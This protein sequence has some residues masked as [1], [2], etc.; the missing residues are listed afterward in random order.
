[1]TPPGTPNPIVG[2][3]TFGVD[4]RTQT[5]GKVLIGPVSGSATIPTFRRLVP[6]DLPSETISV[7]ATA[8]DCSLGNVFLK[9]LAAGTG[10]IVLHL[11]NMDDGQTVR[12]AVNNNVAGNGR[13]GWAVS[14]EAL[15][16]RGGGPSPDITP[17]GN[18]KD[19]YVFTKIS[20]AVYGYADQDFKV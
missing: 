18:A 14:P 4:F 16:W 2:T 6:S 1:M 10:L 15:I 19:I 20:T 12:V 13:L 11:N 3:G 5:V 7:A 9:T 17:V 8:V